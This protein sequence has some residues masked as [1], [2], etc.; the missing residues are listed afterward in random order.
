MQSASRQ[1]RGQERVIT[2]NRQ[3]SWAFADAFVAE[4]DTLRWARDRARESGLPSVSPGTGAALRLLAATADAKAVAEVGT[5]TG[6]SGIYLLQGMR[7]DGVLTTVDPEPD[8]Q[9]FAKEAFRAAG[10]TGNRARFIPGRAL[11]VLPRLADGGYDLVFCDG[12]RME[13]LDYLAESLR[14][15]R[16]GGL[17]CFE[18]VFADGR[19]VDS[20]AQP[21][22]VLRLRELL[23]AVRESQELL[24]SLLPVGD[25]LL[26][27]VRR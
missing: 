6:V 1:L 23:R 10:F 2:A 11:D 22:E 15:L 5:G 7:P 27:A 19:T 25:G 21:A 20:A 3:T 9:Q 24:P 26:C 4:D 18:G 13:S 14:L 8:R 17:V 12:D 16:P